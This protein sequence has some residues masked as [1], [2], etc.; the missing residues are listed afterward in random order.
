VA[1][2]LKFISTEYSPVPKAA[3]ISGAL[4]KLLQ[5]LYISQELTNIGSFSPLEG[6]RR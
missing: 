5:W 2:G 1:Q 3:K 4:E 6:K